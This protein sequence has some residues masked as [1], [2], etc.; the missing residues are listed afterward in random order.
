MC[1]LHFLML[2]IVIGHFPS[3]FDR[4]MVFSQN[5]LSILWQFWHGE[6]LRGSQPGRD[7]V[8]FHFP[9]GRKHLLSDPGGLEGAR[10]LTKSL[11]IVNLASKIEFP[12]LFKILTY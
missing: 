9:N 4:G 7:M 2:D 10:N 12:S 11:G 1:V 6:P 5:S 8:R 3:G